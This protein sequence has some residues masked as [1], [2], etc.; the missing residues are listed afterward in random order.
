[1]KETNAAMKAPDRDWKTIVSMSARYM[2][3]SEIFAQV[4]PFV[5][6]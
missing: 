5:N 2:G 4:G 6:V 3:S 1:M